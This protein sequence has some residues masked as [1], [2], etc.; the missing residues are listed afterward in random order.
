MSEQSRRRFL[1]H[2]GALLGGM[3]VTGGC[4]P[5][6]DAGG[7]GEGGLPGDR[8]RALAEV[9]LPEELGPEGRDAVVEDFRAWLEGYEP[10]PE[11]IHGYGDPEIHYGAADPTGRWRAQ[12]EGLDLEAQRRFERDF[13]D[14]PP[15]DR[16]AI[17]RNRLESE[18][19]DRLPSQVQR[20]E[21]VAVA[22]LAHF[23]TSP[24]AVDLCYQAEIQPLACRSLEAVREEPSAIDTGS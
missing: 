20:A 3:A 8:L 15:G 21:H 19:A 5:S 23:Y 18:D 17:L 7:T 10:V 1:K 2:S 4:V 22:L 12:L 11:L 14:L 9:A 13:K 24:D 16:E 6:E